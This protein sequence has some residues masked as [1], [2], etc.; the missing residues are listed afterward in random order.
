MVL[1]SLPLS[2]FVILILIVYWFIVPIQMSGWVL[3][4]FSI[5]VAACLFPVHTLLIFIISSMVY[6][7]GEI[8]VSAKPASKKSIFAFAVIGIL[9]VLVYYKYL[10]FFTQIIKNFSELIGIPFNLEIPIQVIPIGLSFFT[11]RFIHYLIEVKGGN[12]KERGYWNFLTYTFFFPIIVAGPIERYD[13]F[14]LQRR[15]INNFKWEYINLGVSRILLGLFKKIVIAD[16]LALLARGL[17]N[18]DL[19]GISYLV[20]VYAFTLKIYFDFSGYS[21]IAIGTA[22]LFGFRIMENFDAP[23]L[24]RNISLFWK[25]WH[26][27]LTSWFRD[28]LFIPLGGSRGSLVRTIIN[29]LIVMMAT[30]IWHGAAWHFIAWGLYHST[31]LIVFR[32]YNYYI[33]IHL[34][35]SFKKSNLAKIISIAITFNFTAFG[36][37]FFETSLRQSLHV[38]RVVFHLN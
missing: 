11:F 8:I 1:N 7:A 23:Y 5:S 16:S 34:S 18:P 25:S 10:S 29:T 37:V 26:V 36:W 13:N 4:I 17:N 3:F 32:L 19:D 20:A 22:R 28:Y 30:G 21:D 33:A 14:E 27:S 24:Q 15:N 38:L 6:F 2:L 35:D 12:I 9:G 31:G